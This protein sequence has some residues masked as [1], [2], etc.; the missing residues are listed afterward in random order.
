MGS[1]PRPRPDRLAAKLTQVRSKLGMTQDELAVVLSDARW[2]VSRYDISK[3]EMGTREPGLIF[4]LRYARLA[5]INIEI[6]ADDNL[7]LPK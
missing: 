7:D 3:F 1:A 4:M 2:K 6:F 5:R